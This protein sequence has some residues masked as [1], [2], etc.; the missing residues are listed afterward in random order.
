[1]NDKEL[2]KLELMKYI[3]EI[4]SLNLNSQLDI[5]DIEDILGFIQN[6]EM[7][8]RYIKLNSNVQE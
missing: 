3:N 7:I 5:G 2:F 6:K 4:L 8:L 1:M